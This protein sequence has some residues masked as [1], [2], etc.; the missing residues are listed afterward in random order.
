VS[1]LFYLGKPLAGGRILLLGAYR[2]EDITSFS[3]G[4]HERH[5]LVA[6]LNEFRRHFGEI[7]VDLSQSDSQAFLRDY[8]DSEPNRFNQDFRE[9][10]YH[11]IGGNALFIVELLRALQERGELV[12]DITGHWMQGL[13]LDWERL[14]VRVEAVIAERLGLLDRSYLTLLEAASEQGEV[15]IAEVLVKVLGIPKERITVSLSGPLCKQHRLVSSYVLVGKDGKRKACY[16]FCHLLNQKYL[17]EGL[18]GEVE[19]ARLH[20]ATAEALER[21]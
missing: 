3:D 4:E 11:H 20:Q 5:P 2:P 12:R 7:Q 10:L 17:Y 9:K 21:L 13:S 16:Q 18:G 8:L 1:L 19:R 6:V 14:R 15:F